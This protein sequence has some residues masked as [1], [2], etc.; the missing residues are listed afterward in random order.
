MVKRTPPIHT[1]NPYIVRTTHIRTMLPTH[2][3]VDMSDKRFADIMTRIPIKSHFKNTLGVKSYVTGGVPT[4]QKFSYGV[5]QTQ[6]F[7][8]KKKF[9][10]TFP[11]HIMENKVERPRW[12]TFLTN[13]TFFPAQMTPWGSI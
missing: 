6:D 1:E 8:T 2:S 5:T 10:N 11:V 13:P 3:E 7:R 4:Q 12:G 9:Q